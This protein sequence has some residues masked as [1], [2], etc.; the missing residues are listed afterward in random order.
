[1][2]KYSVIL[3]LLVSIRANACDICG[4]VGG[5]ATIGL[6]ASTKYHMLGVKTGVQSFKSLMDGIVHSRE[7]L[8][9][10][11]FNFRFQFHE[12]IQV[13]GVIPYQIGFQKRDLGNDLVQGLG[14]PMAMLNGILWHKKDSSGRALH[15]LSLS[16]GV[17]LP[18]GRVGS[19]LSTIKNLYPGTGAWE[20]LLLLNYTSSFN[21]SWS[22]QNELSYAFKQTNNAGYKYGN[23]AQ[24]TITAV[25]NRKLGFRR[26]ISSVGLV[27]THFES[28]MVDGEVLTVN[29]NKG[30]VFAH[31]ASINLIGF[32]WIYSLQCQIPMN[33]NLN[34]RSIKQTFGIE[35]GITYLVKT[36][37]KKHENKN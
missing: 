27:Y 6:F 11:E 5:N 32:S 1:M 31:R 10:N 12:R 7:F 17:K 19:N 29:S 35:A 16:L 34:N 15:F 4:G 2:K 33:Q 36:K 26:L 25:N 24:A 28:S 18:I 8:F 22:M 20:E 37:S 13:I 14:D 30:Y 3:L 23:S 21:R 9:R